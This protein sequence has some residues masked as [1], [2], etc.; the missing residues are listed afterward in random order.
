MASR[1][2]L[3]E[4]FCE[5]LGNRNGYFNPPESIKMSY[6]CIRYS[7]SDPDQKYANDKNYRKTNK[8]EG[9]IIDHDPDSVIPDKILEHFS[10]CKMSKPYRAD[11]LNHFPFTLYY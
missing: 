2:K 7:L 5:I 8:Y 6:P 10:M 1:L 3:H 11:G 4:E 9:V